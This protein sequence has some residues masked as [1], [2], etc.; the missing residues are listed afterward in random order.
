MDFIC[1]M[2]LRRTGMKKSDVFKA[3]L[4]GDVEMFELVIYNREGVRI[5]QST[6]R[7]IGWDGTI[8]SG[9]SDSALHFWTCRY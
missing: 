4:Y 6:N 1:R 7:F 3:I 9:L 8:D 5:F 2:H